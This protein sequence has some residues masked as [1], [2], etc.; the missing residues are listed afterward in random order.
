MK[1][2]FTEEKAGNKEAC[3]G[4]LSSFLR[5]N[6]YSG[7]KEFIL[8]HGGLQFVLEILKDKE[9]TT[10]LHKKV[11]FLLNDIVQTG[12]K[13]F[14]DKPK[15]IATSLGSSDEFVTVLLDLLVKA[16][17]EMEN[18]QTW[19]LRENILLVFQD[20]ITQDLLTTHKQIFVSHKLKLA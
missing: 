7:K 1:Q 10:R 4:A 18:A 14:A 20:I 11:V 19:D 15:F 2:F 3:F 12:A 8:G 5:A 17:S 6:N 9:S 13:I 16:S